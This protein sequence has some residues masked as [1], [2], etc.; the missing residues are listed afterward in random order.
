MSR[1]LR[2]LFPRAI[3]V[4]ERYERQLA[5]MTTRAMRAELAIRQHRERTISGACPSL[6]CDPMGFRTYVAMAN[7]DLWGALH[8]E[9]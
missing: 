5:E 7:H 1:L 2:F 3:R 4:L 6:A 8:A 9:G